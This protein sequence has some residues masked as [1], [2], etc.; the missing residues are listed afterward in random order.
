M[1]D[2]CNIETKIERPK[3]LGN[4]K[5]GHITYCGIDFYRQPQG[6]YI[7]K[8][9]NMRLKI[10]GDIEPKLI[11]S[12]SIHKYFTN[13]LNWNDFTLSNLYESIE[14]L[15]DEFETNLLDA[16]LYGKIEFAVNLKLDPSKYYPLANSYLSRSIEPMTRANKV[17]GSRFKLGSR[18]IKQYD[19]AK[20][21]ELSREQTPKPK[22][23]ILRC[24]LV[25]GVSE[26]RKRK[27]P[28]TK[29]SDIFNPIFIEG[30]G[31]ELNRTFAR[32]KYKQGLP[33]DITKKE[34]EA[35]RILE[36][37]TQEEL[38]LYKSL[39]SDSTLKLRK[40]D[41][42][43]YKEKCDKEVNL[44][45]VLANQIRKKWTELSNS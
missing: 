44:T 14:M 21:I 12:N 31:K 22:N 30:M 29:V 6:Y 16:K 45:K 15:S 27:L 19:T 11:I 24:E 39:I 26:Y 13:G 17:Y 36:G 20:K 5:R 37:I 1:I 4:V 7:G 33:K 41:Y 18:S 32:I 38:T 8:L 34:F 9:D 35:Y 28:L 43:A 25:T 3:G 2:F 10:I 23:K 42:R 40:K